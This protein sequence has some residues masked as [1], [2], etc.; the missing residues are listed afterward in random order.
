MWPPRVCAFHSPHPRECPKE[1]VVEDPWDPQ[2]KYQVPEVGVVERLGHKVETVFANPLPYRQDP[3]PHRECTPY[4]NKPSSCRIR[5][6]TFKIICICN[7]CQDQGI[8]AVRDVRRLAKEAPESPQDQQDHLC[9][10]QAPNGRASWFTNSILIQ[11]GQMPKINNRQ[12]NSRSPDH[13]DW[14]KG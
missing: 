6:A 7:T 9:D 12:T 5:N 3:C 11:I 10:S 1:G 4:Q 2:Q 8:K 13:T 14:T